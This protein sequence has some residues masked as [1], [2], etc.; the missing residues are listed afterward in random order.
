MQLARWMAAAALVALAGC[1]GGN[2]VG[3]SAVVP[4]PGEPG[5]PD[6]PP[7]AISGTAATGAPL[8]AATVSLLCASGGAPVTATT[9]AEG[10]YSMSVPATCTGPYMLKVEGGGMTLYAFADGAGNINITPL[11]HL[12]AGIAT[13]NNTAAEYDAV[14]N[15]L[16]TVGALWTV[17][18]SQDALARLAA[19]LEAMDIDTAGLGDFLHGAFEAKPGNDIDDILE[20]IKELQD[21]LPLD[22]IV[23]QLAA[24][25]GAPGNKPWLTLFPAGKTSVAVVGSSCYYEASDGPG[26]EAASATITFT[27]AGDV[28]ETR[29]QV[30]GVTR[31][32]LKGRIGSA[33]SSLKLQANGADDLVRIRASNNGEANQVEIFVLYGESEDEPFIYHDT[34]GTAYCDTVDAPIKRSQL[35]SFD[36]PARIAAVVAPRTSDLHS[37]E[38]C[39]DRWL[40][41]Y[42]YEVTPL[43]NF[44]LNGNTFGA[45]PLPP[46]GLWHESSFW[47]PVAEANNMELT[48]GFPEEEAG[49]RIYRNAG[50][51]YHSCG[52]SNPS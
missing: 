10:K 13:G 17:A 5:A 35:R 8:A 28:M 22:S 19:K 23:E 9:N 33:I 47:G 52:M 43:G 20:W 11:T 48:W 7:L 14:K 25:G 45:N 24:S 50:S 44:S 26:T 37:E 15:Q 51:L 36:V 27:L 39:R 31:P 40:S 3:D 29:L 21:G 30:A 49:F 41:S 16:K 4:P 6:A 12:A 1:G 46:G 38:A 32:D 34:H 2:S 18:I 42:D